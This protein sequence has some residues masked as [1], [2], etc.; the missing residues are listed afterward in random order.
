MT[1]LERTAAPKWQIGAPRM[2]C[3]DGDDTKL[4]PHEPETRPRNWSRNL[5]V[6]SASRE[7]DV[8]LLNLRFRPRIGIESADQHVP[9]FFCAC[10]EVRNKGLHQIA[11][12]FF[13]GGRAAE[14]GGVGFNKRG[15][16][17]V[18]ANQQTE[19]IPQ[20]RLTIS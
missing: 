7:S 16:E 14:I 6:E 5:G 13:Q 4:F 9:V 8:S 19:L 10:S 11:I 2:V 18:L 12:R 20:A 1:A 3:G 17:I 15:I